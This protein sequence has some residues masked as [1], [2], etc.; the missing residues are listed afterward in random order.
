[1]ATIIHPLALYL[2]CALG[3]IGVALALPRPRISPAI[4]GGILAAAGAGLVVV[5][6]GFAGGVEQLPN[7]AF[8][9]FSAMALGGGLRMITHPRPVYS[10][11]YFILTIIA[12]AGLLLILSAEFMAFA[13]I[14]IYAG[15]I[16]ITYL[17]VI[18]LATQAPEEGDL[19]HL[20]DYDTKGREPW[21][22]SAAGFVLL[23]ILT[24]MLFRG[25]GELPVPEP[26]DDTP[27]L[28]QLPL[29]V[30]RELRI[31]RVPAGG[32]EPFVL[33][34]E[35]ERLQREIAPDGEVLGRLAHE[36]RTFF[37]E[38]GRAIELPDDMRANNVEQVGINLLRDHPM[39]IEIAGVLL[40]MAMLGATVLAR[41]QVELEESLKARQAKRL[42]DAR[43][44]REGLD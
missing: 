19:E 30:E 14:I 22:M 25:A 5:L 7:W 15:A 31:E 37:T 11:L 2:A 26:V 38:D 21:A 9:V 36:G 35:D 39:T 8:Y 16:L 20:A 12:S 44:E 28:A 6:L 3:A 24:T 17:F 34:G 18:M 4:F 23:G 33:L 41:K 27:V 1:M 40:L 32:G 10:A 42:H 43:T 13:L 29:K